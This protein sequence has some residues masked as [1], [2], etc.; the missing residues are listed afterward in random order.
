MTSISIKQARK[1]ALIGQ[2]LG[3]T[4]TIRG[5]KG[6][7]EVIE[8]IG[9]V[10]IDTISIVERA[11]H[12]T[13]WNRVFNYEKKHLDTLVEERILFEY[14][15]HAAA[16][17]PMRDFRFSLPRMHAIREGQR[18]W[19]DKNKKL[20]QEVLRR[21]ETDGPLRAAN[22]ADHS[23]TQGMWER[24][25]IK[26]AIE[27]LFMEG[28][29]LVTR[30]VNFQKI[31]D[32]AERVVPSGI[33]TRVPSVSEN[34]RFLIESYLTSNGI[35]RATD[36]TYLRKGINADMRTVIEEMIESG[37]L[38]ELRIH[39][40]S[41][42]WYA[43]PDQVEASFQRLRQKRVKV[44]SPFDNLVIQRSRLEQ[45]FDYNYQLEC[46]IPANKRKHGYF[47]MP[48]LW[49]DRLV[50]RMDAKAD[51][52]TDTFVLYSISFE[53]RHKHDDLFLRLLISEIT[54]FAH[55]CGCNQLDFSQIKQK[56]T[57]LLLQS[58]IADH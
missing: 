40:S 7:Q 5:I 55:Y 38:M 1:L 17:L 20:M 22:F 56:E 33:D 26:Q 16:F 4:Q 24:S 54:S 39:K 19:Y 46:Y 47:C 2:H 28:H 58:P 15:S 42:T 44:L 9:Y 8:N 48:I 43:R 27:H 37:D 12:H 14:W 3:G 50:G 31:F 45:L 34:C 30:R 25:P 49:K 53:P 57:K 21:F 52:K 35:G 6:T 51:R 18:H 41:H 10:Q 29:L 13:L 23:G 11:H 36:F 32:L